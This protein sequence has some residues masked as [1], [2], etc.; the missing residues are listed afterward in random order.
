MQSGTIK[1]WNQDKGYG[2]IDVDEQSEDVFFHISTTR[3]SA[4]ISIGQRV[5]FNSKRNDKNQLRATEVTSTLLSLQPDTVSN[6]R[7]STPTATTNDSNRRSHTKRHA[8]SPFSTLLSVIAIIAVAIYF[9]GDIKSA[10]FADYLPTST[11]SQSSVSTTDTGTTKSITGDAQIDETLALIKQGGPFPYPNKDGTTFYNREGRLPAQSSGYY[12]EYTV[13]T[14]GL[15]H[16]GA[17]RIITGGN[18]P[19]VYYLTVDH[20]DS[21]SPLQVN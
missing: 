21:F 5:Y 7:L 19:T 12:R 20:Y 13:P 4:P 9:F 18:P 11:I 10:L 2:F 6:A 8:K 16:R 3:L 17:R 14:P 1:H 15:S